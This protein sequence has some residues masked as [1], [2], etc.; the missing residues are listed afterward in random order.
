MRT[1]NPSSL[2]GLDGK[3]VSDPGGLTMRW[4]QH[5][6]KVLN[7]PS[8]FNCS[9]IDSVLSLEV[10]TELPGVPNMEEPIQAIGYL[11]LETAG[12]ACGIVLEMLIY[13]RAAVH[14]RLL[15]L[16]KEV[17]HSGQVP[18]EWREIALVPIPKK[19][20]LRSY[21]NWRGISLLDVAG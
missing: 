10:H 9:V 18:V 5:F 21:G 7:V 2:F 13:G 11:N 6:E 16:F 15:A 3:L 8:R 4:Q 19:G 17:W 1:A 20:D 14:Q 12:G